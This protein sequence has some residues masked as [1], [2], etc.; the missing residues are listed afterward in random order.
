MAFPQEKVPTPSSP[1]MV[2]QRS[3][4]LVV[5]EQH[6]PQPSSAG[7]GMRRCE[8]C[9]SILSKASSL[10]YISSPEKNQSAAIL[11]PR[12][13][14]PDQSHGALQAEVRN[15]HIWAPLE[16]AAPTANQIP[17]KSSSLLASAWCTE[18]ND[19]RSRMG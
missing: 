18:A 12:D 10:H 4:F 11:T 7:W 3:A 1:I 15:H 13:P 16:L 8:D 5:E 19:V 14:L 2:T 17:Q 9:C 6:V